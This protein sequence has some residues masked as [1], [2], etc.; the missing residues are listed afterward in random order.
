MDHLILGMPHGINLSWLCTAKHRIVIKVVRLY[1]VILVILDIGMRSARC[2]RMIRNMHVR[3]AVLTRM[4]WR[5]CASKRVFHATFAT[6]GQAAKQTHGIAIFFRAYWCDI[7]Y[8]YVENDVLDYGED[9]L[10]VI[11][12]TDCK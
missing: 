5:T 7:L 6:E 4:D 3:S 11:L 9:H 10:R 8:G 2:T 1:C 12:Y